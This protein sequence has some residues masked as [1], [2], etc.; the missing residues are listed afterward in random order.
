MGIT[1]KVSGESI[2]SA[3]ANLAAQREATSPEEVSDQQA[4]ARAAFAAFAAQHVGP[5][6]RLIAVV[7]RGEVAASPRALGGTV[8]ALLSCARETDQDDLADALSRLSAVFERLPAQRTVLSGRK[9][10]ALLSAYQPLVDRLPQLFEVDWDR[11]RQAPPDE[12]AAEQ[13]ASRTDQPP[14]GHDEDTMA[15]L[16]REQVVKRLKNSQSFD[17]ED[18]RGIDLSDLPMERGRFARADL[19]GANLQ[20]ASLAAAIFS[21][22]NL[23]A[24]NAS[25]ADLAGAIFAGADLERSNLA[26][27][28]LI[29]ADLSRAN[30]GGANLSGANLAGADLR[31]ANLA[32]AVITGAQLTGAKVGAMVGTGSEAPGVKIEW[33]DASVDGSGHPRLSGDAAFAWVTGARIAPSPSTAVE[34]RYFGRGDILRNATIQFDAGARVE[35]DS[36]F[37]DCILELGPDTE[38][39]IGSAG[40]LADCRISG[41]GRIT[42][43]GK[44]FERDSPGIVGPRQIVVTRS[45]AVVA[46]VQQHGN[47]G[48]AFEHGCQLRMKMVRQG[49][50]NTLEK[51]VA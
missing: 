20:G 9:G 11:D 10:R 2:E 49:E 16:S 34:T 25:G 7:E 43:H 32:G 12:R 35:I 38:L 17:R 6:R 30:L 36:L 48:F 40:V 18:L 3:V 45:A 4:A 24:V 21:S 33:V 13:Q 15:N 23:R 29:G 5:L 42:V 19:E 50:K 22:A 51:A 1:P 27:A 14:L 28:V 37:Q 47:T 44:F 46:T 8:E 41:P 39:V 26:G 31:Y